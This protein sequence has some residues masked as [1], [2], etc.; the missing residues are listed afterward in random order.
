MQ[1]TCLLGI[2]ETTPTDFL[3]YSWTAVMPH[4]PN[5]HMC[6]NVSWLLSKR[7]PIPDV[8]ITCL[9]I[10]ERDSNLLSFLKI[11][12]RFPIFAPSQIPKPLMDD[13]DSNSESF[14]KAVSSF[15][16]NVGK[17]PPEWITCFEIYINSKRKWSLHIMFN[18]LRKKSVKHFI[19]IG[20][21]IISIF[22]SLFA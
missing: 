9:L 10:F 16:I 20:I 1:V 17:L 11:C 7:K 15:E 5:M 6:I 18:N 21:I 8:G 2:N 19:F 13:H 22:R 3:W 14:D 12:N 4:H